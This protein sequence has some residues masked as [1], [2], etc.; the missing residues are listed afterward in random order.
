M[1]TS[2]HDVRECRPRI[3]VND[4]FDLRS[5]AKR[6]GVTAGEVRQ[7]IA[8][9]GDHPADVERYLRFVSA[10]VASGLIDGLG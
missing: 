9:V 10:G 2:E 3:D 6:F 4:Y 8:R 7:A 5:W 1:T